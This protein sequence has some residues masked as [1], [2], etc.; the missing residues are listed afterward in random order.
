MLISDRKLRQRILLV[1]EEID[2]CDVL[3]KFC[4][5]VFF[6]EEQEGL[7]LEVKNYFRKIEIVH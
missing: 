3:N 4:S 5:S 7:L 6:T 1:K 2:I